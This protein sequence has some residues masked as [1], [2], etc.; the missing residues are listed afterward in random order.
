MCRLF[1]PMMTDYITSWDI[2]QFIYCPMITWIRSNYLVEEPSN[3]NMELGKISIDEKELI[4]K[5]LNLPQPIRYE[6]H[7]VSKKLK[8]AGVVDIVAGSKRATVVEVKKFYRHQVN[9][10]ETQLKFYAYLVNAELTPVHK[11]I[12]KVGNKVLNYLISGEELRRVEE[13]IR[14]VREVREKPNPPTVNTPPNKCIK[15]WY[16][17]YCISHN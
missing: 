6:V 3:P 17:R 9:H 11:A 12:L 13:L 10:F 16:R 5:E 4:A 15:C 2:K 8:A 7:I 14:K 1:N